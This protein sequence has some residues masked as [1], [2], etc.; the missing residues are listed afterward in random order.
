MAINKKMVCE[1]DKK[2]NVITITVTDQDPLIAATVADSVQIYLQRAITEYR[3][4]KA[5]VDLE[6]VDKLFA[7]A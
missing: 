6:Y 1:V 7:E 2:T 3:T 5:R 4:K